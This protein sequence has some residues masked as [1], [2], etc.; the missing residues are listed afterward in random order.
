[1]NKKVLIAIL[2][3]LAA[4]GVAVAAYFIWFH[5]EYVQPEVDEPE[6]FHDIEFDA[7]L[8][9]GVWK[10]DEVY[11]RYNDDG[12][13]VTWDLADDVQED[14]GTELTWTLDGTTFTHYY[15]MEIGGTIPKVFNMKVLEFDLMEYDDDFGVNH[16]FTKVEE[17]QLLN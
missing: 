15:Y 12:T 4:A 3:V 2:I 10:E 1:M 11:Y 16:T 14:E 8:L 6:V 13:A 9:I 7:D 17:L 5:K